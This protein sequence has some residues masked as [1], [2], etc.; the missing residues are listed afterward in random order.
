MQNKYIQPYLK[1]PKPTRRTSH[2]DIDRVWILISSRYSNAACAP[3]RIVSTKKAHKMNLLAVFV[4]IKTS[5]E[6][7]RSDMNRQFLVSRTRTVSS[8]P[9]AHV[10]QKWKLHAHVSEERQIN[11]NTYNMSEVHADL[12][13]QILAYLSIEHFWRWYVSSDDICVP[14]QKELYSCRCPEAGGSPSHHYRIRPESAE[15]GFCK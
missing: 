4:N 14:Q 6:S 13:G 1:S 15:N 7:V 10:R 11:N 12:P 8:T 9:L 3:P 5:R 2:S